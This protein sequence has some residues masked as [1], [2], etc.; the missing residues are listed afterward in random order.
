MCVF[1]FSFTKI[2][3]LW[4]FRTQWETVIWRWL[5]TDICVTPFCRYLLTTLISSRTPTTPRTCSTRPSTPPTSCPSAAHS[6]RTRG[7]SSPTSSSRLQGLLN[8]C[9]VRIRGTNN[10]HAC[11]SKLPKFPIILK[12]QNDF[13][14]HHLIAKFYF[15]EEVTSNSFL[16]RH[17]FVEFMKSF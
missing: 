7:T 15:F 2:T 3:L 17:K 13:R 6:P 11:D 10:V 12:D 14:S 4:C 16:C 8:F 9:Y 5:S 1:S